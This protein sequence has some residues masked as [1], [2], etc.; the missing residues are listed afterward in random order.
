[1]IEPR[2]LQ[3]SPFWTFSLR[4]YAKAGVADAC[5]A[6]QDRQGVDVN[7]L[8]FILWAGR[9]G[10]RLSMADVRALVEL[11]EDWR[12]AIV[13]PLRLVRRAL[14]TPP[15][16]IDAAAAAA[17]RQ[18]VKKAELEAERLQQAALFAYGPIGALGAA[19]ARSELAA[20]ANVATY[21][22]VLA[23][24][25]DPVPVAAILA[26]LADLPDTL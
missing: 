5:L 20:A 10:R 6:L 21:A 19:E 14:R 15:A 26:A 13:V 11:T 24:N 16:A 9:N 18:D 8:F 2:P 7:L 22:V 17:L 1:M 3:N 4:L 23:T 12:S 25:F